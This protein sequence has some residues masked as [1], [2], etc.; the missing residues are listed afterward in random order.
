[1]GPHWAL[2]TTG[3]ANR[4]PE[5]QPPTARRRICK[6]HPFA[7]DQK[8]VS[9]PGKQALAVLL[10]FCG[11]GCRDQNHAFWCVYGATASGDGF[12][13]FLLPSVHRGT[14]G[15][16]QARVGAGTP[17]VWSGW[18]KRVGRRQAGQDRVGGC[19]LRAMWS[20]LAP[21]APVA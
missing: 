15:L 19:R 8:D 4:G 7:A 2:S 18:R 13:F 14:V 6:G 16:A 11:G 3:A 9:F 5:P 17:I 21:A 1:M 12:G 10:S 20:R